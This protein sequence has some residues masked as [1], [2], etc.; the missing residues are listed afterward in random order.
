MR[1]LLISLAI[2]GGVGVAA[3]FAT[4][5]FFSDTET[6]TDNTITAGK[7]DLTVD[8]T[9]RYYRDGVEVADYST[10]HSWLAEDLSSNHK[11]YDLSDVKPGDYGENTIS[12]HIDDNPA[13]ACMR[14][15]NLH[16]D[17]VECTEPE[18]VA[19]GDA[20][21][22]GTGVDNGAGELAQNLQFFAWADDGDNIYEPDAGEFDEFPL[23]SNTVGPASDVLNGVTYALA[24]STTP[25][26]SPLPGATTTY[27][28]VAWCAGTLTVVESDGN[29][30]GN[31]NL[32]CDGQAMGNN[33]QA[34][35]LAA[36][37]MFYIEQSRNNPDFDCQQV[38][39]TPEPTL[40][41][42][43]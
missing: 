35:S 37:I 30:A 42:Q 25:G 41:N 27:I 16:N 23:F 18:G 28:G 33:T 2:I 17:E 34:D 26:P 43:T 20:T 3:V 8:N 4:Q 7:L 31:P 11:F 10:A 36:D 39:F 21:C 12:L 6:S 32:N 9:A 14:I 24:D 22:G 1:R 13:W 38:P 40:T 5:A 29:M 19:E 15:D